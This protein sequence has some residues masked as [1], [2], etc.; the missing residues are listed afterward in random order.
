MIDQPITTL[1]SGKHTE[2]HLQQ[3]QN[4]ENVPANPTSKDKVKDQYVASEDEKMN[5]YTGPKIVLKTMLMPWMLGNVPV[6]ES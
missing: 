5:K 3:N 2:K 4:T 1:N 6:D